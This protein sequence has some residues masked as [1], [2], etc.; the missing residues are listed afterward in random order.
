MSYVGEAGW[1]ITCKAENA[2]KI[3]DSIHAEGA[4]PSGIF[5]QSSMRIEK[6]FLAYGHDLDTDINP[7]QAGLGFAINWD[8]DF[9]GKDALLKIKETPIKSKMAAI[10]LDDIDAVPLGNEPVYFNRVI[11][12]KTTSAAFGYRVGKPIALAYIDT[13]ISDQLEGVQLEIDIAR[14]LYK[15]TISLKPAFDP[16]GKRMRI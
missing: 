15:G 14:N 6:N 1:E 5:S 3:Y 4:R 2:Q 10:I 13:E 11:V 16:A 8:K 7:L 12:G 9:I